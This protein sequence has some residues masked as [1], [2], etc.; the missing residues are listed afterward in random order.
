MKKIF[1]ILFCCIIASQAMPM[2]IVMK[3]VMEIG[4]VTERILTGTS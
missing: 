2:L 1:F 4:I 3:M